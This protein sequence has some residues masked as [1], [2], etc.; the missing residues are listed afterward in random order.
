M[1]VADAQ[2]DTYVSV[3]PRRYL[4]RF[5]AEYHLS[6]ER[7]QDRIRV[8]GPPPDASGWESHCQY[9]VHESLLRSHGEFPCAGDDE[10]LAFCREIVDEMVRAYGLSRAEAVERINQHWSEPGPSGR[11][12]RI[13]IV[14]LD[15]AYHQLAA[16]W[17]GD[18]YYGKHSQW[19]RPDA[20]PRPL[21]PP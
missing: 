8:E 15:L 18:M 6:E 5:L 4:D 10:A 14:G 1:A 20:H 13:W 7:V 19:W 9:L 16:D 11:V 2:D 12:P 3:G 17:A 21:P